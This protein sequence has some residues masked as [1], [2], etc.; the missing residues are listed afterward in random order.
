MKNT[1]RMAVVLLAV[2]ATMSGRASADTEVR[3]DYA[4]T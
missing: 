2:L 4:V 1:M 3:R